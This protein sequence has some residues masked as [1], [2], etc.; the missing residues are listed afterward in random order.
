MICRLVPIRVGMGDD[1]ITN[2]YLALE[3]MF[4][5]RGRRLWLATEYTSR[6]H[7]M[8]RRGPAA[9]VGDTEPGVR[10]AKPERGGSMT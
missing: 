7:R 10:Q 1:V 5:E 9:L 4:T 8:T 3:S 2:K 6:Q